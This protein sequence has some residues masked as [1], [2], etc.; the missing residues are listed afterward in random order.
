MEGLPDGAALAEGILQAEWRDSDR[1][2]PPDRTDRG[3]S[4]GRGER[5]YG[6]IY[7][8]KTQPGDVELFQA[9]MLTELAGM[10]VE[11]GL[12]MQLHPG[13]VRN[14]NLQVYDEVRA[15]QGRGYS[16]TD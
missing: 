4:V 8:G 3:P 1:P 9:Q 7:T 14:Y 5:L 11:D 16:V 13:S 15:R 2:R 6:R 10:S 12:T